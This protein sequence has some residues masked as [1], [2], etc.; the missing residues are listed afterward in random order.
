ME[1]FEKRFSAIFER[2]L[3]YSWRGARLELTVVHGRYPIDEDTR[4]PSVKATAREH[5]SWVSRTSIVIEVF[6]PDDYLEEERKLN[7]AG[8]LP[9]ECMSCL[10]GLGLGCLVH[11]ATA[12]DD[13]FVIF[14]TI[15]GGVYSRLPPLNQWD[16]KI[17]G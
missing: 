13:A 2:I 16:G 11:N 5:S 6:Y 7:L 15:S 8:I 12:R 17:A 3:E 14:A 4:K 9:R 10:V 1:D